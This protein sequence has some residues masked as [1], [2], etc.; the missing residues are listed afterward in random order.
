MARDGG[1][2]ATGTKTRARPPRHGYAIFFPPRV[3]GWGSATR[4]PVHGAAR[5]A[6]P[7]EARMLWRGESKWQ[8][9]HADRRVRRGV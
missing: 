6:A 7:H 4:E 9:L 2:D 1:C 8:G 3:V 5:G